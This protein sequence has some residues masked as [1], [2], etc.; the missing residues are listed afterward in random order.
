MEITLRT[1]EPEDKVT[2]ILMSLLSG[3]LVLGVDDWEPRDVAPA[4]LNWINTY[5]YG[6]ICTATVR[7]SLDAL[8]LTLY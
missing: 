7:A 5:R 3:K 1:V 2:D 8:G 4:C 6:D